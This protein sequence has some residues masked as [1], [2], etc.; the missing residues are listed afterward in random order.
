MKL[1]ENYHLYIMAMIQPKL[2][3]VL[4]ATGKYASTPRCPVRVSYTYNPST[5]GAI[6]HHSED[7]TEPSKL[8][9][10]FFL[11][12]YGPKYEDWSLDGH[13]VRPGHHVNVQSNNEMFQYKC[14]GGLGW[15]FH[16]QSSF[17]SFKEGW[18][19]YSENPVLSHDVNIYEDNLLQRIG[20][21]RLLIWR[22]LRLLVDTGL[23]FKGNDQK[24]ALREL[25]KYTWYENDYD[26]K[27]VVRYMSCPGQAT[28]YMIGRLAIMKA[29]KMAEDDLKEKFDI[30]DFH[31]QVLSIGQSPLGYL[32]E[33]IERY[34]SCKKNPEQ[35]YCDL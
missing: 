29:R 9:L 12:K 23:H 16:K 30:R 11:E 35:L 2:H 1:W 13:E 8:K 31:Y 26:R 24:W 21:W 17:T 25:K 3:K 22:A 33:H 27:S 6:Y 14:V 28:S 32:E 5:E 15:F 7:C 18:A 19:L 10:P 20:M 4:H 34:L